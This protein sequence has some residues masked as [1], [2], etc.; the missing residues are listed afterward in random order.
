MPPLCT[1]HLG[2]LHCSEVN[3]LQQKN[4]ASRLSQVEGVGLAYA[5]DSSGITTAG[6]YATTHHTTFANNTAPPRI[7]KTVRPAA[8]FH[9]CKTPRTP[10]LPVPATIGPVARCACRVVDCRCHL[11]VAKGNTQLVLTETSRPIRVQSM[12]GSSRLRP[13]RV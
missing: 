9:A 13:F 1:S 12:F 2:W 10:I 3:S 8:R 11:A 7:F 6:G 4:V 5:N